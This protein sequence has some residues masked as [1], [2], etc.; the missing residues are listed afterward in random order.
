M[1]WK[2]GKNNSFDALDNMA[3]MVHNNIRTNKIW[4]TVNP[5]DAKILTL[6]TE[7]NEVKEE[8]KKA[9]SNS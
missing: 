8:L 9:E 2:V 1:L 7:A 5:K 3:K 4:S 6:C